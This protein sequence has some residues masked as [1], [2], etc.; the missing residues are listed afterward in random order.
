MDIPFDKIACDAAH[1][2]IPPIH[3]M[4]S[5]YAAIRYPNRFAGTTESPPWRIMGGADGTTLT[6]EPSQPPGAPSTLSFGQLVVFNA[7]GPFIVKSQ[8]DD[9]PFYM[10]AHMTGC[11][12][13]GNSS[14]CRGDP[15]Y[16]NIVPP[17]QFLSSY[18]FFTDPTYPETNLVLV[19]EKKNG[20]FSDVTVDCAGT[21]SGWMPIDAAD[22]IEYTRLDLVTGNFQSVAGCN[23]GLHVATSAQPFGLVVWGWGSAATGSFFSQAVSYAYPAGASVKPI[24]QV[25]IQ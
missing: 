15:E 6:Y 25:I 23:N 19:R 5:R 12:A 22:T 20:V 1:Q 11:Y 2:Q 24:N 9:H 4:G 21:V 16:V 8:D 10:S 17:E 3:A 14:D 7:P 18:T 13:V